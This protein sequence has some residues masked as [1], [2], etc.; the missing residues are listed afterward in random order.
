MKQIGIIIILSF[1]LVN[2][3]I[4]SCYCETNKGH[5]SIKIIDN[6]IQPCHSNNTKELTHK[7]NSPCCSQCLFPFATQSDPK[8]AIISKAINIT[9][10]KLAFLFVAYKPII[11]EPYLISTISE[12]NS[13][14]LNSIF[15]I[16]R[17]P[18][19]PPYA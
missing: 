9:L 13:S 2:I 17:S 10:Y 16:T 12:C 15:Q 11:T 5:Y 14:F 18:R 6:D 8:K 4:L 1:F 7:K 3:P 19:G